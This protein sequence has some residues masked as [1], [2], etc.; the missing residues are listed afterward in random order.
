MPL[1]PARRLQVRD[2]EPVLFPDLPLPL[3]RPTLL[4]V[5]IHAVYAYRPGAWCCEA[6]PFMGELGQAIRHVVA[7]QWDGRWLR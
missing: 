7:M 3:P 4:P 1:L 2:R 5:E 6:C